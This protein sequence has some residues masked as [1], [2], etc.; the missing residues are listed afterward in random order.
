M[1]RGKTNR[2][3]RRATLHQSGLTPKHVGMPTENMPPD[4]EMHVMDFGSNAIYEKVQEIPL[5]EARSWILQWYAAYRDGIAAYMEA[6]P[7]PTKVPSAVQDAVQRAYS[8][9]TTFMHVLGLNQEDL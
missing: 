7:D 5:V 3:R 9:E 6:Y 8:L 4:A 1:K 2:E